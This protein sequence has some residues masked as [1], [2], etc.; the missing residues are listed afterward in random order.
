M[1][2]GNHT[3]RTA[4][5]WL[6]LMLCLLLT[7][8]IVLAGCGK[9]EDTGKNDSQKTPSMTDGTK[10]DT[11][12]GDTSDEES[13]TGDGAQGSEGTTGEPEQWTLPLTEEKKEISV[14][15]TYSNQYVEDLNDLPTI[16]K[17]E[18]RTNVHVNWI[19][20]SMMEASE[21]FGLMLAS[22]ELPDVMAG[23]TYTGGN[24]KGIDDGVF[25]DCDDLVKSYMPNYLA[26]ATVNDDIR[27]KLTASDGKFHILKCV[28]G[29]N[30]VMASEEQAWNGLAIRKDW[31]DELNLEVPATIDEWHDVLVAFRDQKGAEAPL[32]TGQY[33]YTMMEPFLTAYGVASEFYTKPDGTIGYGPM[34]EG[35]RQ[36]I[37]LFRA[38]YAEGLIDPNFI[39]TGFGGLFGASDEAV[40]NDKT[41]GFNVSWNYLADGFYENGKYPNDSIEVVAVENPVLN[42]GDAPKVFYTPNITAGDN[43][44]SATCKDPILVAKWLDYWYTKEAMELNHY[45]IEGET[46]TTDGNGNYEFTD[47][48]LNNPEGYT[49]PDA[50][51]LYSVAGPAALGFYNWEYMN[52]LYPN[53]EPK[54]AGKVLWTGQDRSM[55]LNVDDMTYDEQIEFNSIYTDVQTL[56][57]ES[58]VKYIIGAESMDSYDSF[59]QKLHDYGID[60]CLA[61]RQAQADRY[62]SR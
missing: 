60:K 3:K 31:L 16:Q 42:K 38:W 58:T 28:F 45:G 43:I 19:T 37:E 61:I 4:S 32:S 62:S 15:R 40:Y 13:T 18:E 36:W 23:G 59:V 14:W 1:K 11:S 34:E 54:L 41:G 47:L 39:T 55:L 9:K 25:L 49:S 35:Y 12:N 52:F 30:Q 44:I 7:T 21:K 2:K 17:I 29:N 56:V 51:S 57:Q 22:G 20:V 26:I 8:S 27:K 46:Y 24:Q 48:I 50:L 6:C 10:E 5:K 53:L 33:G